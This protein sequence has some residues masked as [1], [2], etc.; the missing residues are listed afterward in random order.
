MG[1]CNPVLRGMI[2]ASLKI[3]TAVL[4]DSDIVKR[5]GIKA[6]ASYLPEL[7]VISMPIL[8]RPAMSLTRRNS[9]GLSLL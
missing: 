9:L 4:S 1:S 2:E 8:R 3:S 6:R 5:F 7:S